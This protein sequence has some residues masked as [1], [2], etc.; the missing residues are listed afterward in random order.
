M[1][2]VWVSFVRKRSSESTDGDA[3]AMPFTH[4]KNEMINDYDLMMPA[5]LFCVSIVKSSN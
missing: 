1:T 5:S 2:R 3:P 4:V